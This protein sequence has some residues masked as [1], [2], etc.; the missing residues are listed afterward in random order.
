MRPGEENRK[1][2]SQVK[3]NGKPDE[4]GRKESVWLMINE[5]S[6][7]KLS[8]KGESEEHPDVEGLLPVWQQVA[9]GPQNIFGSFC[10]PV[11]SSGGNLNLGT[12]GLRLLLKREKLGGCIS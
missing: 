6:G 11:I 2:R 10:S 12:E 4:N 9:L 3:V 7:A 8:L 1:W 5:L